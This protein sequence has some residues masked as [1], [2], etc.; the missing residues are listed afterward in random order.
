MTTRRPSESG[1]SDGYHRA[2]FM[3]AAL[4]Q[5]SVTGSKIA[6]VLIPSDP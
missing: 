1:S 2:A 4:L 6:V 3:S 5:V